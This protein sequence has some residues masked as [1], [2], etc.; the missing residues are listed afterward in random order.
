MQRTT[1]K[2]G[3]DHSLKGAK[4]DALDPVKDGGTD[5]VSLHSMRKPEK[6]ES[7]QKS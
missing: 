1:T 6:H 3:T 4:K 2:V 7:H 5:K